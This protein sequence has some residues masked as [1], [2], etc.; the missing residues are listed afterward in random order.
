[1]TVL[2]VLGNQLFPLRYLPPAKKAV[3]FMA[4]DVGLCTYEKHHQQKIVLFL[5]AMR[6][7]ADELTKA[8][9]EVCYHRLDTNDTRCYEDKLAEA[10][11]SAGTD[12]LQHFEIE[13]KAMEQRLVTFATDN[14][15][16]RTELRSPMFTCGR[17]EFKEYAEDR[18]RLK[19]ADFYKLQRQRLGILVEDDGQPA[20][21][22]WS[23]DADNRKKLPRTVTPPDVSWSTPTRHAKDV[24]ELVAQEFPDHPGEAAE[25]R[26]PTTRQQA[27]E[28]LD[29][30][31][32]TR[33]A[34]FG[35]YEDALTQRSDTV[36]HSV[37]SPCLNLGLL[38]PDEVI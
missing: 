33:L 36:F 35:P 6:S 32:A 26:W 25:F 13:D 21:G 4:E 20:G 17:A 14:E 30:F 7:Y 5:A 23:F 34:Q 18:T 28:W 24:I 38:T 8:G 16:T 11:E 1:M 29:N 15:F 22:Q 19:M 37:L 3:V 31:V 10:M 2:A 27:Q 9:Y 12:T